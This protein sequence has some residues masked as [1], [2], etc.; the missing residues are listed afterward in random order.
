MQSKKRSI[1]ESCANIVV[2]YGISFASVQFIFPL[3]D[4]HISLLDNLYIGVWFTLISVL[5]SYCLRRV[6]TRKD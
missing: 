2:G 1:I 4:Y 3:F 6:F 5:R